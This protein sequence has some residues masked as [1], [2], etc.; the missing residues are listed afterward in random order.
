MS[1]RDAYTET[2]CTSNAKEM[3][4]SDCVCN[5]N[6]RFR[7]FI[8]FSSIFSEIHFNLSA[9]FDFFKMLC[10]F[11]YLKRLKNM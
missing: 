1:K 2:D 5:T 7:N 8:P 9:F 10:I 4:T 11:L 3:A 6:V